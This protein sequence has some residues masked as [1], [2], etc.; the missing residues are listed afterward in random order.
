MELSLIAQA[1]RRSPDPAY[2]GHS[3]FARRPPGAMRGLLL[4]AALPHDTSRA[5]YWRS[6][7]SDE[8]M[9]S[10]LRAHDPF[11]GGGTILVEAARLGAEPSGMDVDPLAVQIVKHEL[12][13][14][15]AA[16]LKQTAAKLAKFV[17]AKCGHLYAST[18][19]G[20]TPLHY[21]FV[22]KVT[23][24]ACNQANLLYRDLVIA[25]DLGKRGGVQ[26]DGA[27]HAFCP[28][29][30]RVHKYADP[31]RKTL[32]CCGRARSLYD[33]SFS[34]QSFKCQACGTAS[35]HADLKTAVSPRIL[36]A[37]EETRD[38][39]YRRIRA[40]SKSDRELLSDAHRHLRRNR[41]F[42]ALPGGRFKTGRIDSRPLSLGITKPAQLFTDRQLSVFGRGFRWLEETEMSPSIRRALTLGLSNALAT[43]NKF[44]GY[45]RDYGRI[46]PLFSVRGYSLPALSVELNP[47]HPK[48][49]RGTL[50]RIFERLVRSCEATEVRRYVWSAETKSPSPQ[51][52]KFKPFR[53]QTSIRCESA[54]SHNDG[55][56]SS[57][58]LCVFDPP[59]FDYIAYS[60]LSEFHRAWLDSKRL[61]GTPLLP[62]AADP[63]GSFATSLA[64]CLKA[65]S[66]RLRAGRPLAFTY[67]AATS[68][69][70]D[71][72]GQ[73]LDAS[74]LMVTALWPL[75]NDIHMGHHT[76]SGNCEWDVVVVCRPAIE[77]TKAATRISVDRWREAIGKLPL[78]EADVSGLTHALAMASNRFG[79]P[80]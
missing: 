74:S 53:A 20:W 50:P 67:H 28:D 29:C 66:Q 42:L 78:S 5:D 76:A 56:R 6:F 36:V 60:E 59:Y 15:D 72:V 3:W 79:V 4:A 30:H 69:A 13:P 44:C 46:A 47:F 77:C 52:M 57:V 58:D 62:D 71:A 1:D 2:G 9:L 41:R 34:A 45:A 49:G 16:E 24:P 68:D 63:V 31:N 23:C 32:N 55:D 64:D 61:G 33:G 17:Q 18:R 8:P 51:M 43:N 21:F 80:N 27:V 39:E 54:A 25:R 37:V 12:H 14:P 22:H 35:M 26:R 40:P 70:W 7:A 65:I 38:G 11:A 48:A 73:A 75:R 10:G 19:R